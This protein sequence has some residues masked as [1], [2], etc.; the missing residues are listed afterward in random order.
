MC[1]CVVCRDSGAEE[2]EEDL[3]IKES[4][5][6]SF[7]KSMLPYFAPIEEEDLK[8]LMPQV[9]ACRTPPPPTTAINPKL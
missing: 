8:L 9:R 3:R 2:E 1:V 6:H 7:W 5:L 4:E